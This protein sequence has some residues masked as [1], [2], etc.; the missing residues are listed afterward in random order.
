MGNKSNYSPSNKLKRLDPESI[1]CSTNGHSE[2]MDLKNSEQLLHS[3]T[4]HRGPSP[5]TKSNCSTL[6]PINSNNI[7]EIF[8][9]PHTQDIN[10]QA[11]LQ[12]ID[13]FLTQIT[14]IRI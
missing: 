8:S 12:D 9:Q 10:H 1:Q 14:K 5:R 4:I 3:Q 11:V 2:T 6:S 7:Q 13:G